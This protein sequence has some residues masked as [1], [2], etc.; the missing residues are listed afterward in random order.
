MK[1]FK[2]LTLVATSILALTFAS[3]KDD[4]PW[5]P[6]YPA[7]DPEDFEGLYSVNYSIFLDDSPAPVYTSWGDSGAS[8]LVCVTG[9]GSTLN[10]LGV[11]FF[12]G[13][14]LL[15]FLPEAAGGGNELSLW[16]G[17]VLRGSTG[18]YAFECPEM[19]DNGNGEFVPSTSQQREFVLRALR[20]AVQS[21]AEVKATGTIVTKKSP[22]AGSYTWYDYGMGYGYGTVDMYHDLDMTV[23]LTPLAQNDL[24]KKLTIVITN[25]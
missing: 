7:H 21:N 16:S 24:F 12:P 14:R 3:C 22:L 8:G 17:V 4:G 10:P 18:D 23:E 15:E 11:D 2:D 1:N 20:P 13:N 5:Y 19:V 6:P 9:D 25:R